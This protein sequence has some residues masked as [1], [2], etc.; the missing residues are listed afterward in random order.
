MLLDNGGVTYGGE[1]CSVRWIWWVYSMA[2]EGKHWLGV[3]GGAWVHR[4]V[5]GHVGVLGGR[6]CSLIYVSSEC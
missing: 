6:G 1:S 2:L 3:G 4:W 5:H